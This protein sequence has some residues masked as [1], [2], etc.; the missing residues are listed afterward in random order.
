M[1]VT[2]LSPMVETGSWQERTGL[3]STCT[4]QAPQYPPPHPYLVP[5]R[6]R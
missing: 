5:V 4:V 3:P 2:R 6:P 1:V